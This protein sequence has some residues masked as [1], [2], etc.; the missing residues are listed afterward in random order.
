MN[1][2]AAQGKYD[3]H[4][5]CVCVLGDRSAYA[6][7][8][9]FSQECKLTHCINAF[10]DNEADMPTYGQLGC[11]GFIILDAQGGIVSK[12]TSA[13]KAVRDLAFS[14]VEALLDAICSQKPLPD[15]CPGEFCRL[16]EASAKELGRPD[17]GGS[18][19]VC[20]GSQGATANINI[21][22]GRLQGKVVQVATTM[23]RIL[24]EDQYFGAIQGPS[25]GGCNSGSCGGGN[26]DTGN[27]SPGGGCSEVCSEPGS[28][29]KC[30]GTGNSGKAGSCAAGACG[31][32]GCGDAGCGDAGAQPSLDEEF[33]SSSL[34]LVSVKVPSMDAE[35]S[36]C[37]DAMR[38]LAEERSLGSLKAV[39]DCLSSHFAHEEALF[40]EFAFGGT[41]DSHFSAKK[42]H[43]DDHTRI[44]DNL[45]KLQLSQQQLVPVSFVREL[46]RDFHEHTSRYDLLYAETLSSKGAV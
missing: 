17:L 24:S 39:F 6:L 7:S 14:H 5:L 23:L 13:A 29:A 12:K 42:S 38:R 9:E 2:W 3:A 41:G 21:Q 1:G 15:I 26:C 44:L 27:C 46:L 32:A 25:G 11:S 10:V 4:F 40:E 36:E 31:D 34:N 35:H 8:R 43:I 19:G 16:E 30:D 18:L 45:Q 33:V 22:T 37:A 28:S 20:V